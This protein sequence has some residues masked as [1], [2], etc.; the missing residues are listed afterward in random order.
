MVGARKPATTSCAPSAAAHI[1]AVSC[2]EC[3]PGM[4]SDSWSRR[5]RYS[6]ATPTNASRN[7]GA[8]RSSP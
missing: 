1:V 6:I 2:I 7:S 8:H 3:S 4:A 5:E